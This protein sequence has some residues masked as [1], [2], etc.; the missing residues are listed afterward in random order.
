MEHSRFV[1]LHVHTD[2]SLLD[3]ACKIE[4][5]VAKARE[6]K[7]P[8]LAITDH[9]NLYGAVHFYREA[10]KKGVKPIIGMEAYVA[11]DDMHTKPQKQQ[12]N[13]THITLLS[14]N[15]EGY[16]NLMKL[17]SIAFLEGFYYRPRIDKATLTENHNGL[18]GMSACLQGE[19]SRALLRDNYEAAEKAALFYK[20]L[21]GEGNFY[22]ELMR[23]GLPEADRIFPSLVRLANELLIP[24][25][26]TND[27]HFLTKEDSEAHDVLLAL[28]TKDDLSSQTRFKM[29]T[30]EVYFKSPDEMRE[31]FRDIPEAIENTVLLAEKCNVDL[32]LE[33]AR[34][35]L[36]HIELPEGF[37]NASDY[38]VDLTMR[39][40]K[41]RLGEVTP[42]MQQRLDLELETIKNMGLCDYCLI[43]EDLIRF[44][45]E[46]NIRVGPGRGSA[47]GSLVLYALHIT[48][49]NPLAFGLIFERFL[50]P[51]RITMPDVD[52][53]FCDD[54]R[55]EIIDYLFNKYGK[56]SVAQIITFS[57]LG[58]KGVLRDVGRVLGLPYDEVDKIAKRVPDGI[59]VT[60]AQALDDKQFSQIIEEKEDYK[61]LIQISQRLEGLNR[62]VSIHAS[63]VVITPGTL[64]DYV[65]LYMSR[66][67]E[68]SKIA[69]QYDMKSVEEVGLLKI[70]ILGLRTLT[71][72]ENTIELLAERGI[73]LDID[74]IPLDDEDTF[75][76]LRRG[77][78][79]GIF[80]VEGS[81]MRD[82]LKNLEP[83]KFSD[84]IAAVALY[85]PGPMQYIKEFILKKKGRKEITYPHPKLEGVLS[86]TYGIM[87]YQE[88]VMQAASVI[89]NFSLGEADILRRA[90]G[91]K[92]IDVMDAKRDLFIKSAKKNRISQKT[93]EEIFEM[94]IPFA[95]Y[96]FNKSHA[97]GYAMLAYQTAY[98]KT[99]HPTEFL[100]ASL[101]SVMDNSK[102]VRFFIEDCRNHQIEVLPPSVN[103][104]YVKFKPAQGKIHFGLAAIKNVGTKAAQEIVRERERNGPY[105]GLFD[106]VLRVSPE[107]VNKKAIEGLV[108]SGSFDCIEKNR[109][110]L[111]ATIENALKEMSVFRKER[112]HGQT[113]LFDSPAG[114][115]SVQDNLLEVKS[116]SKIKVLMNENESL[117]LYLS[118][119]PYENYH[120]EIK[121]FTT[122]S[123]EKLAEIADGREVVCGGII[124]ER[125]KT[126]DKK[127]NDMS[128]L[129]LAD[130]DGYYDVVVFSSLYK[131][132]WQELR[133]GNPIVVKGQKSTNAKNADRPS[134]VASKIVTIDE[135]RSEIEQQL[136]LHLPVNSLSEDLLFGIQ[137]IVDQHPGKK[138][139]I[140]MV[141]EY[142][143]KLPITSTFQVE[144]S[145]ELIDRLTRLTG[146][147]AIRIGGNDI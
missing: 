102:K 96:G 138:K 93:A 4:E 126:K 115:T 92:M 108:K 75:T 28:Q 105:K 25:V 27:V 48:N 22:I 140:V 46:R 143:E 136:E 110:R 31:L 106:F 113:S 74:A 80:Q 114:A 23:H 89:A 82:V 63:G 29:E 81:G 135:L 67:K 44:A 45:K 8:A 137:E 60:I 19:V 53:D 55:G 112:A 26:A 6:W 73:H 91:K 59:N 32:H 121:H 77:D 78:T 132:C 134:I 33:N 7:M 43:I 52:I 99:H 70:D 94:M 34:V 72:I 127:G 64:T 83:D 35:Q 15:E 122:H 98:L 36:P 133:I 14:A 16:K 10:L 40:M 130:L 1:H 118:G 18:I 51:E 86:D 56:N 145:R 42:E 30:R 146:K 61:K 119:H 111:F 84:I 101:S 104:S 62:H 3:G 12:E 76:L 9:G 120:D 142:E 11:M 39:G 139:F 21:F 147:D 20:D 68:E 100:S 131:K 65:P 71:V 58:A 90:M 117:G 123:S 144:I 57:K 116:W 5:I 124:E 13:Y 129:T 37:D 69:T 88:Q 87:L 107:T 125:R 141:N 47:A 41:I 103:S 24:V 50:N 17:S 79:T 54:R 109:A 95:G 49:I 38:L 97:A 2:Y 85:R 128:F 66:D